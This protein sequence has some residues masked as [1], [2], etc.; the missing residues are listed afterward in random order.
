M[1]RKKPAMLTVSA[2]INQVWSM[3]FMHDQ[4]IN[5]HYVRIFNLI[6]AERASDGLD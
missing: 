2:S 6:D 1:L 4:L 3:D 5:G